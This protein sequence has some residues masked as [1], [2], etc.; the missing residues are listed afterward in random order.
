MHMIQDE[1]ELGYSFSWPAADMAVVEFQHV[2]ERI[3]IGGTRFTD[4]V[5]F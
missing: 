4:D 1:I 5:G 2:S 3:W